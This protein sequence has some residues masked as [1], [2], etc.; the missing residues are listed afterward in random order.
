[1]VRGRKTSGP[2]LVE[3]TEGSREAKLRLRKVLETL[4]GEST[5]GEACKVLGIGEAAFHKLRSRL[6]QDAVGSLERRRVGRPPSVRAQTDE[7][8]ESLERDVRRLERELEASRIREELALTMPH[9][10][11]A[12]V[13][14]KKKKRR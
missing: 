9:V 8:L 2:R 5:I 1:L 3:G 6:L 7:Q 12:G 14:A 10:L 13:V 11:R 4:S